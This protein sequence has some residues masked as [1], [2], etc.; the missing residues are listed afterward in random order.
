MKDSCERETDAPVGTHVDSAR[1]PGV[2]MRTSLVLSF[3][4]VLLLTA[5][6]ILFNNFYTAHKIVRRL[7]TTTKS[8][9]DATIL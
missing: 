1:R 7:S 3:G 9:P 8:F 2:S 4:G 6:G 5:T